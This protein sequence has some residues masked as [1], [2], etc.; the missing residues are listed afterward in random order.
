MFNNSRWV[1]L[2][3]LQDNLVGRKLR[4]LAQADFCK[5]KINIRIR[6]VTHRKIQ[7]IADQNIER[8]ELTEFLAHVVAEYLFLFFVAFLAFAQ[9]LNVFHVEIFLHFIPNAL[10]PKRNVK[11]F[12]SPL[13]LRPERI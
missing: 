2:E 6:M 11:F 8:I 5:G 4:E 13:L 1:A 3:Y 12:S 10:L 9:Y 7:L